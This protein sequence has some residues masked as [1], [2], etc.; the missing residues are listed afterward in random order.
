MTD[1]GEVDI[2]TMWSSVP[3]DALDRMASLACK[4]VD[5]PIALLSSVDMGGR[6]VRGACGLTAGMDDP[7]AMD[8]PCR[9]LFTSGQAFKTCTL[10]GRSYLAVPV[11]RL[12]IGRALG[13][14]CVV[15]SAPRRW[16][17]ENVANLSELAQ[18]FSARIA[19]G[20][21]LGLRETASATLV[22][23]NHELRTP[24]QAIIGFTEFLKLE[25]RPEVVAAHAR[26]IH[27]AAQSLLALVNQTL[28]IAESA[29]DN[30]A[31]E[32][33]GDLES[34][35]LRG[36]AATCL[37]MVEP[38]AIAKA[39]ALRLEIDTNLPAQVPLDAQKVR[40]ALLNLLNN[41]VKFT[42]DG[43]VTLRIGRMDDRLRFDVSDTGI[44]I[45]PDK[46]GLLFQRFSRIE[47]DDRPTA[48]TGLGLSITK[49]LVESL[50]GDIGVEANADAG[51]TFWFALPLDVRPAAI[52]LPPK[53]EPPQE[54]RGATI[55]LADDLDLN[56]KLIADMLALDGHRV[57]CVADGAAAVAAAG[58]RGY[59][60]ILMDMIMPVMDG[61]AA[62]RAIRALPTP[63]CDVP[64][65]ALTAHSFSEQLDA[66]LAA[67][68]DAT[69][70]KPMS[71]DALMRAVDMWTRDRVEAA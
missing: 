55:L 44:G 37:S 38:A 9:E 41:A 52:S 31:E 71:I 14:L 6:L 15:D 12:S 57:E 26:T 64:I 4:I 45:D 20:L 28:D 35:D 33:A 40:Q 56:R 18:G 34:I 39:L 61:L 17:E 58:A 51:S 46:R 3:R 11:R 50:S 36:F 42:D 29:A 7:Q 49:D 67:G 16:T 25:T 10:A 19:L 47:A 69:L 68:M 62:T 27:T 59:D 1:V 23:I 32:S 53:A 30:A 63:F 13:S 22:N 65:V 5:A 48:G 2:H 24:L 21:E 70:T 54:R 43:S 60:L 66:C 8:T